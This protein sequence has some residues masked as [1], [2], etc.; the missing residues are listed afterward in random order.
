MIEWSVDL[1]PNDA[2]WVGETVVGGCLDEVRTVGWEKPGVDWSRGA[3]RESGAIPE[4]VQ[5]L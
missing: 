3:V 5:F 1:F 4:V 2:V